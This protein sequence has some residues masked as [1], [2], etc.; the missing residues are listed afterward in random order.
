MVRKQD[1]G[2]RMEVADFSLGHPQ[3]SSSAVSEVMTVPSLFSL[4]AC[5][6]DW[7]DLP[8]VIADRLYALALTE[9]RERRSAVL[10]EIRL[11][12][13]ALTEHRKRLSAILEDIRILPYDLYQRRCGQD[14][15]LGP[16]P[17]VRVSLH[18]VR[19]TRAKSVYES[20]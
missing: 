2:D 9:H 13:A 16:W 4:A 3:C 6:A 11:Y 14:H 8:D 10:K 19:H 7:E 18:I 20:I 17:Y 15:I 5:Q 1:K 12:T